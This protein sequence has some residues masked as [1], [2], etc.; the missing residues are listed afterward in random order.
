MLFFENF[1]ALLIARSSRGLLSSHMQ[2]V[3]IALVCPTMAWHGRGHA[4]REHIRLHKTVT[5]ILQSRMAVVLGLISVVFGMCISVFSSCSRIECS[6]SVC[7]LVPLINSDFV[8]EDSVLHKREGSHSGSIVGGTFV[9]KIG[10]SLAPMLGF[11]LLHHTWKMCCA[12]GGHLCLSRGADRAHH[13]GSR[14]ARAVV[15]HCAP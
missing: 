10:Q 7:R 5:Y 11:T 8:D 9:G 4:A 15:A 14:P 6:A 1:F 2:G 3:A 12:R 13:R